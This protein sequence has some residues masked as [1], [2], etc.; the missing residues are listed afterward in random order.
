VQA[1]RN[2]DGKTLGGQ[3]LV[4]LLFIPQLCG[5]RF[6]RCS[7]LLRMPRRAQSM[8]K[9]LMGGSGKHAQCVYFAQASDKREANP[10]HPTAV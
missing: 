2:G 4:P 5:L 7:A 10:A 9:C 8:Q 1:R 6:T 3:Q